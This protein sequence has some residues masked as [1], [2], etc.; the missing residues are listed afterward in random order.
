MTNQPLIQVHHLLK[1]SLPWSSFL[2]FSNM[3][4]FQLLKVAWHLFLCKD[5]T[6]EN[7]SVRV[8]QRDSCPLGGSWGT[9]PAIGPVGPCHPQASLAM[10]HPAKEQ[11]WDG[12][13]D[14]DQHRASQIPGKVALVGRTKVLP[15]AS[16]L[17]GVR[18]RAGETS[19]QG[20]ITRDQTPTTVSSL[21]PQANNSLSVR[22]C[23]KPQNILLHILPQHCLKILIV[24]LRIEPHGLRCLAHWKKA[25]EQEN[26]QAP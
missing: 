9:R 6:V 17:V 19:N 26:S 1:C 2:P 24:V 8:P 14:L 15:E 10:Q 5:N 18:M 4:H 25:W 21:E 16:P 20:P 3:L 23:P 11:G 7:L 22:V 13:S 12:N